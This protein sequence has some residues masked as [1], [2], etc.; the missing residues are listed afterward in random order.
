[1]FWY[2]ILIETDK[3]RAVKETQSKQSVLGVKE[4]KN[5]SREEAALAGKGLRD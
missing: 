4:L 1:M 3:K 5:R 2:T